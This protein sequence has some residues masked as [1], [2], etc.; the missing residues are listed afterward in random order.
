MDYLKA[1]KKN[2]VLPRFAQAGAVISKFRGGRD[3]GGRFRG[4]ANRSGLAGNDISLGR[5]AGLVFG[6]GST[7]R[8]FA[9][10]VR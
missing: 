9:V 6:R 5:S 3:D 2:V 1:G 8:R 10:T 7:G 4:S